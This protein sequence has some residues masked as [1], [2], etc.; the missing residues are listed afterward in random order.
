MIKNNFQYFFRTCHF[1]ERDC[2]CSSLR[3]SDP[4]QPVDV[5][6]L[7]HPA[8][9][10]IGNLRKSICRYCNPFSFTSPNLTQSNQVTHLKFVQIYLQVSTI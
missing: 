4:N 2:L 3:S 10:H 6:G 1:S 8:Q 7:S 5:E 9:L